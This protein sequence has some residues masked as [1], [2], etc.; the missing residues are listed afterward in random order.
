MYE[1]I[2]HHSADDL[3]DMYKRNDERNMIHLIVYV[4]AADNPIQEYL[5]KALNL[6][7]RDRSR[8][9]IQIY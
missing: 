2:K 8:S 3:E 4:H 9:K 6:I 5:I 1:N 7:A